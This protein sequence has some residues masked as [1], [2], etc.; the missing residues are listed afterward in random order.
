VSASEGRA[1]CNLSCFLNSGD[2]GSV[3]HYGHAGAPNDKKISG[4]DM[5]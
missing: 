1:N 5:W 2:N 3:L 4:H